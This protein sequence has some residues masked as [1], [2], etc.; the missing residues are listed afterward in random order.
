ME[1]NPGKLVLDTGGFLKFDTIANLPKNVSILVNDGCGSAG[2]F[3]L[4]A[5]RQSSKVKLFGQPSYGAVDRADAYV[6]ERKNFRVS[7]PISLRI[8]EY[9]KK[10]IDNIG[11]PPDV[12]LPKNIDWVDFVIKY[13]KDHND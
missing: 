3:F 12:Y 7:I 8:P 5:A 6:Y 13:N 1:K 4:L 2:E 9:Y 10:P 11:I